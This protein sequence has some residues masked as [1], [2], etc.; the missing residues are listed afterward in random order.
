MRYG[1]FLALAAALVGGPAFATT[2]TVSPAGSDA[3]NGVSAPFRTP[4]KAVAAARNGDTILIQ[5]GTYAAGLTITQNNLT[6]R[7]VGDVV[8]DGSGVNSDYGIDTEG[9]NGITIADLAVKNARVYGIF[10]RY[11]DGCTVSNCNVSYCG[12]TGILTGH[13]SNFTVKNCTTTY[14]KLEHGIY[15][16]ESGDHLKVIGNTVYGNN[17]AGLQINAVQDVPKASD[18]NE[19]SISNDCLIADNVIY[20]NSFVGGAAL[21]LAGVQNSTIVNNL[22]YNDRNAG[23]ALFDDDA[24]A[25]YASKNNRIIHNT[26]VLSPTAPKAAIICVAGCTGNQL[27]NNIL[28]CGKNSAIQ[29][30]EALRSNFNLVSAPTFANFG[31]L[32]AWRNSTGNDQNSMVGDPK[33]G[34]DYR[35]LAGSPAI[36]GGT[37]LYDVDRGG[38]PRPQGANPDLGCY[39]T[40]GSAAPAVPTP[41]GLTTTAGAGR[42]DLNWSAV[43][44]ST[45]AGYRVYRSTQSGGGFVMLAQS[46]GQATTYADTSVTNGT[47]YFY[48]L[49]AVDSTGTEGA[50]TAAI[51]ATP[52]AAP[53]SAGSVIY[54]DSLL[55]GWS[56]KLVNAS[57]TLA[58][59]TPVFEG[60][61]SIAL[62]I[63]RKDG[64]LLLSGASLTVSTKGVLKF[65]VHGGVKG[66]QQLRVRAMVGGV[67]QPSVSI[68]AY[69]GQVKANGWTEY[70]VPLSALRVTKGSL[71]GIAFSAGSAQAQAYVDFVRVE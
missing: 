32:A 46:N 12:K 39:E 13:S 7:G 70:Q 37:Q 55:S 65:A 48:R 5:A 19:D 21:N 4:Q 27:M 15:L 58:S 1:S 22:I 25:A 20:D 45:L 43:N 57:G 42:V 14:S 64:S 36:D 6:I 63:T 54:G 56:S 44:L 24:G 62:T 59:T 71:N 52:Q 53:S 29:T 40:G 34:P 38:N 31:S 8:L 23:I 30:E 11:T 28:V 69:G 18:P 26:V 49:C 50:P 9:Q 33:L 47:T 35:P 2:Y 61:Q 41:V 67:L 16:S 51:S 66:G 17:A 60:G 68:T 10:F 3:S